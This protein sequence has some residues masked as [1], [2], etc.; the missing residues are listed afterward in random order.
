MRAAPSC[1]RPADDARAECAGGAAGQLEDWKA[2]SEQ[3][4]RTAAASSD[5]DAVR[6]LCLDSYGALLAHISA[7]VDPGELLAMLPEQGSLA[8]FL[9]IVEAALLR[10]SSGALARRMLADAHETAAREIQQ[11]R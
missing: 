6:S 7:V 2:V 10:W 8:Y 9:P 4:L 5:D 11:E 3:L 1:A